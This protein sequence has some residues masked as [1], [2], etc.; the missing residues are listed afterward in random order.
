M[1][2]KRKKTSFRPLFIAGILALVVHLQLVFTD[3]LPAMYRFWSGLFPRPKIEKT[4]E[5]RL[6]ALSE[7]EWQQNRSTKA[8]AEVKDEER[9]AEEVARTTEE[10]KEEEKDKDLKGQ[11]V[12]VPP[13]P[14]SSRPEKAKFLSEHNTNV[15]K[16]S[17]SRQQRKDYGIA[18]SRPTVADF[19]RKKAEPV[20]DKVG[21]QEIAMVTRKQGQQGTPTKEEAMAFELPDVKKRQSLKLKLDMSMGSM[22]TF[23]SSEE[24]VGNS[25]RLRLRMGTLEQEAEQGGD[26]GQDKQ[27]VA[28]FKKPSLEQLDMVTGAPANDH[29]RDVPKGEETMLNS[30]EFRFA[31]F[32]N[33][34]KRGVSEHWSPGEVYLRHDPYGNVYGVKDRYTVLNVE[35]DS[36]GELHEVSVA[37]SSGVVFLDDEAVNAFQGASPFPNPPN[38]LVEHDGIIRFQ[39][40]FYFEIGERPKIRAF[41]SHRYPY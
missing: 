1:A 3:M 10:E 37:Q 24:V 27:T 4:T 2:A 26:Q 13:T 34:I 25:D 12:D 9:A 6:V 7:R 5:V 33:R 14:D 21:D 32:F 30:R 29:I 38:G 35:L 17:V 36:A 15:E 39:F 11:V 28:M 22:S 18:Q 23:Q 16:E 20:E 41:R 19:S 31:T 8:K 40:G